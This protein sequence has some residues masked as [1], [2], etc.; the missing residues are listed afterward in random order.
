V[1]VIDDTVHACESIALL[2]EFEGYRVETAF[3]GPTGIA[4]AERFAPQVV[5]LDLAM[6][7]MSGF[8]VARRLRASPA[9]HTAMIVALTGL[10]SDEDVQ[11]SRDAGFNH[12][13]LKPI[14]IDGLLALVDTHFRD[15]P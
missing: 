4:H 11:R 2:M 10:G 3:D 8:E 9:T 13:C 1:L 6:P 12:H 7:H 15:S 5:L 14:D